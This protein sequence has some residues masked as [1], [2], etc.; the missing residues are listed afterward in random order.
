MALINSSK[1]LENKGFFANNSFQFVMTCYFVLPFPES[2]VRAKP[3]AKI[4]KNLRFS[5]GKRTVAM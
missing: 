2:I 4:I 5:L 1:S 3:R